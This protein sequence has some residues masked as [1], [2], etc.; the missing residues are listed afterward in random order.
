MRGHNNASYELLAL[1]LEQIRC[2]VNNHVFLSTHHPAFAQF[3]ENIH[4]L[5]AI[6]LCRHFGVAQEA[7]VNAGIA[8]RQGFTVYTNRTIL[9]RAHDVVSGIHQ[10]V[11]VGTVLPA[12]LIKG[13]NAHFQRRV[14][15]TGT[16]P[17]QRGIDTVTAFFHGNHGVSDTEG[18]VV[19]SVDTGLGIR[20]QHVFNG[21][22]PV[23]D[24]VHVH[25]AAGVHH[26]DTGST[27]A[28]HQLG[29]LGQTLR[30]LHVAHHQ[31][32][33]GVHAQLAGVLDVLFGHVGFGAVGGYPNNACTSLVGVIQVMNST[34]AGQQQGCDLGMLDHF[35]H[36]FDPL[37]VGVGAKAIVEAGALQA[38]AMGHFDGIHLGLVQGPSDVLHVLDA[39]LV[40]YGVAA[41]AQ[42]H[43]G[44][45][46]FL[47]R[48]KSHV[49]I[50]SV[51]Q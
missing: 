29:L 33:H 1:L 8:Q 6:L 2:N 5:Q 13:G 32:A 42:S 34:N 17:C 21:A 16:L 22:E 45:V 39:V 12:L 23:A 35:C 44:D 28:F 43:V 4:S 41:V 36:G 20:V 3:N 14:A 7:G 49:S 40:A 19:V 26:V 46:E 47:A 50:S 48:V 38:V 31:E 24:V 27:V 37:Q 30:S 51:N 15:S 10:G 11:Q 9:Q 18:Q 25:R